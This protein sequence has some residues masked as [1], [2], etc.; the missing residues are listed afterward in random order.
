MVR[1]FLFGLLCLP[2]FLVAQGVQFS[3]EGGWYDHPITLH[4]EAN[5]QTIYYTTDGSTPRPGGQVY[6]RPLS[7]QRTQVVRAIACLSGRCTAE[8]ANSYFLFEPK[9]SFLTV[10]VAV[11]PDALFNPEYGL[12]REGWFASKDTWKKP[13]ANFWSKKELLSHIEIFDAEEQS[14]F[15][16][17]VGFRLFGGMSRLFAQKSFSITARDRY[18]KKRIN[19]PIFGVGGP[20]K[21]KSLVFRNGGSDWGKSHFR[22][23]LMS[24]LLDGWDLE[25]QDHQPAHVYL[26]GQ[27]WGVYNIREKINRFFLEDQTGEDRDSIDLLEHNAH[28]KKGSASHYKRMLEY[29]RTHDL[30]EDVH[31]N[32]VDRMME[33]ENFMYYQI[34]QIYFD[35]QD[36]G[37]NIRFWRPQR[38]DGRWRWILYDVDQGFGLHN[39]TAYKNNTLAFQLEPNG[40]SWPNPPW[41]TYLLRKLLEN[42]G[43]KERFIATFFDL[44][45]ADFSTQRVEHRIK[46]FVSIYKPEIPRHF[47]RWKL[48][49]DRWEEQVET[50]IQFARHRPE[51]LRRYLIETFNL[52]EETLILL[53]ASTG[54]TL[55]INDRIIVE[56]DSLALIYPAGMKVRLRVE[57]KPGYRFVGWEGLNTSSWEHDLIVSSNMPTIR[58]KFEPYRYVLA[59]KIC[60][61][62]IGANNRQAGDWVE[63][64]NGSDEAVD[65][66]S[67]LIADAKHQ[68]R[69]PTAIVPP[70]GYLVF[71]Q[72][73]QKFK[74]YFPGVPAVAGN[75]SF[76]LNKREES[77]YLYTYDGAYVDSVR[78]SVTPVDT[79]FTLS[80]LLPELD[81]ARPANWEIRKGT[82]TPGAGNP[83]Y[84]ESRIR[85][86]QQYWLQVGLYA[87]VGL[88]L[89]SLGFWRW[90]V[91][92]LVVR[93]E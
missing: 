69:L 70:G 48:K 87:G 19:Y 53:S 37:G 46:E 50:M 54:G 92:K 26:N 8:K 86:V 57:V 9:S 7:L 38:T 4:L 25:K 44:L 31:F 77:I 33:T 20:E 55:R 79:V 43:F 41:S 32:A 34:A 91:K 71:C 36:A 61:N 93:E 35:N 82:G 17:N 89:L 62:E 42:P 21:F 3:L 76:G 47:A 2:G 74:R 23:A 84:V 63:L 29:I 81:N 27:Y 64:F 66:T 40:P 16:K 24:S 65:V 51:W 5:G 68:Y 1:I 10:S 49:P 75:F 73:L 22:D 18:G 11:P 45:H 14:V 85:A 6:N 28:P 72:N 58:A 56:E 67:W 60:I 15:N 52:G 83:F 59:E 39:P 90:R 12:Y 78:Y 88:L 13:G 80:L 30:S